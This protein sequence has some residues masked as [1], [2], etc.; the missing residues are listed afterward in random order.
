M[1][2]RDHVH[3]QLIEMKKYKNLHFVLKIHNAE[4]N[5]FKEFTLKRKADSKRPR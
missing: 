3:C 2:Q 1:V 5:I 4:N